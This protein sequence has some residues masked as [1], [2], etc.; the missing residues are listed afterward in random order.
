MAADRRKNANLVI[1]GTIESDNHADTWCFGLNFVMDH[2]MGQTCI[3]SVYDKKIQSNE[4]CIGTERTM[5]TD[6]IT[7]KLQ[8]LQVNQGLDMQHILNHTLANPN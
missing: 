1:S 7:G 8:L 2:F 5:W 3:V 6:P 4:I